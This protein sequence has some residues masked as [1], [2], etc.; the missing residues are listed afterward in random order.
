MDVKLGGRDGHAVV[1][2]FGKRHGARRKWFTRNRSD[3]REEEKKRENEKIRCRVRVKR[4]RE[5]K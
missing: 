1:A 2:L 5:E 3:R 4:G